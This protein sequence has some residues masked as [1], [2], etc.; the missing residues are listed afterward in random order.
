MQPG[1]ISHWLFCLLIL[2]LKKGCLEMQRVT[3]LERMDGRR[4][5]EWT[6]QCSQ[7]RGQREEAGGGCGAYMYLEGSFGLGR[8]GSARLNIQAGCTQAHTAGVP[9]LW[10]HV[11]LAKSAK[12]HPFSWVSLS[13]FGLTQ[14]L[15]LDKI[16]KEITQ[17]WKCCTNFCQQCSPSPR[18]DCGDYKLSQR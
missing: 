17:T 7:R 13:I 6:Q 3:K 4:G 2:R 10:E 1:K 9:V 5:G 18:S 11:Q 15:T 8:C 12:L 14:S 16:K